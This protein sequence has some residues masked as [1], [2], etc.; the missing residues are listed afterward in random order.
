MEDARGLLPAPNVV[1]VKLLIV[2]ELPAT[3]PAGLSREGIRV[4]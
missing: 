1:V 4:T 2:R 3:A